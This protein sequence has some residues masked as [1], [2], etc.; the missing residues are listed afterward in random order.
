MHDVK[1]C[2]ADVVAAVILG[3]ALGLMVAMGL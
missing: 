2:P 1:T 3:L